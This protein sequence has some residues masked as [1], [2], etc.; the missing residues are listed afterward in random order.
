MMANIEMINAERAEASK[1]IEEAHK[2]QVSHL[3]IEVGCLQEAL[4]REE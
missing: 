3:S 1:A 4:K 2:A